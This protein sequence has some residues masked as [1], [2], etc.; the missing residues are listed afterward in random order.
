[1]RSRSRL[2]VAVI[3]LLVIVVLP[4][5]VAAQAPTQGATST[6]N[7]TASPPYVKRPVQAPTGPSGP[8]ITQFS[9]SQPPCPYT[10]Q[11]IQAA[12]GFDQLSEDGSGKVIGIVDAFDAPTAALDLETFIKEFD[13]PM[14]YG[15]PGQRPCSVATGPHP[16]FQKTFASLFRPRVDPN[17]AFESSLDT[18]W[19]HAIAPGADI[20][21]VETSDDSLNSLLLTG[22]Q[23]ANRLGADVVSMSWSGSEFFPEQYYDQVFLHPS[24]AYVAAS[25][26]FGHGAMWPTTSPFVLGVGGTSLPPNPQTGDPTRPETAWPGSGGGISSTELEPGYQLR[27][28]IPSTGF[29]RGSPDVSYFADLNP[30]VYVSFSTPVSGQPFCL[31][32]NCWYAAGG[33]SVGA[34]QWAALIALADQA[35]GTNISTANVLDSLFYDAAKAD[36]AANYY[37]ITSGSN[38]TCGSVCDAQP[39]YDFVTGLGSP[40]AANLVP[41]LAG[42]RGAPPPP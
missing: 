5:S 22:V 32:G 40:N 42:E 31:P 24:V 20:L 36:Y 33:T 35:R 27:F 28:P 39:G 10:P 29:R 9:C 18:Q 13:L 1:M 30:G 17:W 15:L 21:L 2:L 41:W 3:C 26:D 7:P 38:G 12:Y 37:D 19:A 4:A 34:P 25:N 8:S 16:C 14:M 11:Q 23:T 6:T